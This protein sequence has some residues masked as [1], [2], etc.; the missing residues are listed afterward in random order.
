MLSNARKILQSEI[1]LVCNID[2]QEARKVIEDA[3]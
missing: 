1:M 2:E 3:I